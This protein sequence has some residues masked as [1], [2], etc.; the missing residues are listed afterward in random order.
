LS[1]VSVLR[2]LSG[3]GQSAVGDEPDSLAVRAYERRILKLEQENKEVSRKLIGEAT[4][5]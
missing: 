2:E 3:G 1:D 5:R 4:L